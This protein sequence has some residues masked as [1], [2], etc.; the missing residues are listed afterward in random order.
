MFVQYIYII[1]TQ[2]KNKFTSVYKKFYDFMFLL[3]AKTRFSGKT[4]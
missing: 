4:Y 3:A 2:T 1:F